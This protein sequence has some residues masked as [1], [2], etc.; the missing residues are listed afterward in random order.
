[1]AELQQ[2]SADDWRCCRIL[3]ELLQ[4]IECCR[5][6]LMDCKEGLTSS[7]TDGSAWLKLL[8]MKATNAV[9]SGL[10]IYRSKEE[11]SIGNVNINF[12][13]NC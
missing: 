2:P 6:W 7:I 3:A 4:Q 10:D 12:L 11:L 1:M 5:R 13:I 9:V 8:R